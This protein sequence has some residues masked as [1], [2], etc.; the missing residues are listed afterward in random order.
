MVKKWFGNPDCYR[1]HDNNVHDDTNCALFLYFFK[2]LPDSYLD[3]NQW[4]EFE[5]L[6]TFCA[7]AQFLSA[8]LPMT[9][10]VNIW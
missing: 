3:D 9:C 2:P 7:C 5:N 1:G 4:F 10:S 6:R 8:T